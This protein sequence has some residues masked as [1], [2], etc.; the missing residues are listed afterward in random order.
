MVL[1]L[2]QN[3]FLRASTWTFL[4]TRGRPGEMAI[5]SN[6]TGLGHLEAASVERKACYDLLSRDSSL[7]DHGQ[8]ILGLCLIHLA[9][10]TATCRTSGAFCNSVSSGPRG[11]QD[12]RG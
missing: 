1:L 9:A 11:K 8:C 2:N 5:G 6:A 3:N 7:R 10:E 12:H 4:R